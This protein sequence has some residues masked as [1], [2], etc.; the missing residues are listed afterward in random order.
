MSFL[1][2]LRDEI[3]ETQKIQA[4][5]VR[6]KLL[7]V[8]GL[9]AAG[10]GLSPNNSDGTPALLGLL[11][12]VCLYADSL[13]YNSGI[14]MLAVARYLRH[15]AN[16]NSPPPEGAPPAIDSS[17]ELAAAR[18]YEGYSKD[19]RQHFD[20]E[21]V[22]VKDVSIGV[23]VL[24]ALT[25]LAGLLRGPVPV[26]ASNLAALL[27]PLWLLV[28]CIGGV[29]LSKWLYKRHEGKVEIF[30]SNASLVVSPPA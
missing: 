8:A 12:F 1:E 13:I 14:R 15:D 22:A 3:I 2:K 23:S 9:G 5:F 18:N 16:W 27:E 7:L 24:V 26:R 4:A 10:L 28:T 30:D 11:P 19:A 21:V 25:G 6:W 20:L 17:S 29:C